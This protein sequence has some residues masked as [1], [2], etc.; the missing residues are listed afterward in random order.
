MPAVRSRQ[1]EMGAKYTPSDALT[2]GAALFRIS[3]PFQ[4]AKPDDSAYG[5]TFVQEGQ[6]NHIG[7]ELSAQGRVTEH[8]LLTASASALRARARNTGTPAYEGHPLINVPSTRASLHAD[9]ALPFVS[10]LGI[11]GGWRYAS[12]NV[13]TADGRVR[14]PSYNV[15]DVG[16]RFQHQLREHA[17]NWNLSVD[18][19]FNR[20]YWRD[21]GSSSGDYYLFPGAPRQARLSV[22]VAL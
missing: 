20:F 8:L 15:A 18:N 11:T 13:A 3:Q 17:V 12:S 10:G 5:Y 9:Y 6:Q 22:T 19:V 16:L 1:L 2:L 7:L 21:T 4:Y 14:A